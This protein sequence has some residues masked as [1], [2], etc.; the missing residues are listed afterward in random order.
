MNLIK[1]LSE[2]S[3]TRSPL[4]R[5]KSCDFWYN[6]ING[7]EFRTIILWAKFEENDDVFFKYYVKN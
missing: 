2:D 6:I 7:M 4:H 1:I 5:A 3:S